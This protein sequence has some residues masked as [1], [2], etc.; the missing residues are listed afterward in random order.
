MKRIR[1]DVI[2]LFVSIICFLIYGIIETGNKALEMNV[3]NVRNRL[4]SLGSSKELDN[5]DLE[6]TSP[7]VNQF[8]ANKDMI[9]W[10]SIPNTNIDYPIMQTLEDEEYYLYRDFFGNDDK[11]GTLFMDT[12][13]QFDKINPNLII[14][15][16]HMKSGAMFGNL[17]L[18]MEE[19]Y[20]KEHSKIYLYTKEEKREYE[21]VSVFRTKIYDNES[22]KFILYNYVSLDSEE[23][24]NEFYNN[25]KEQ[26]IYDT[27]VNVEYGD[28]FITLSTCSYHTKNGRMVVIA[29]RIV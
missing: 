13:C 4:Q 1:W 28:E 26:S 20:G 10:I 6:Y 15:G 24:F 8:E 17:P 25:I 14:H 9:A 21:I 7:Y 19:K 12:D 27:N 3:I 11:N 18:F 29:K 22:D 5:V 2:L 16:H 23:K